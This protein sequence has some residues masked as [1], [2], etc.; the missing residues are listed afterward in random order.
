MFRL[1]EGE[2]S[3][4]KRCGFGTLRFQNGQVWSGW[5]EDDKMH[6]PGTLTYPL[7]GTERRGYW[8]YGELL[9]WDNKEETLILK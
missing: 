8:E 5:W 9:L 4:G 6:G 2:W 1:F 7:T 3:G